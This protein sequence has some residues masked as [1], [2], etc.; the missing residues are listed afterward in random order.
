MYVY[1]DTL[2]LYIYIYIYTYHIHYTHNFNVYTGFVGFRHSLLVCL[3]VLAAGSWGWEGS[4]RATMKRHHMSFLSLSL[5][6]YIYI[7]I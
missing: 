7:Y 3:K 6:I 5:Y 2:L 1:N 4:R